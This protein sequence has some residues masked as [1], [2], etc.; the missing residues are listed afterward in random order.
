MPVDP[1]ATW[2]STLAALPKVADTSW[3][4]N[5]AAWVAGRV[6]TITT[7][8][9]N[10]TLSAPLVFVFNQALFASQLISLTPTGDAL[11][12]ITG[13]ADAWKAAIDTTVFPA[14][15]NVAPGAFV[16]PTTPATTFSTVTSVLLDPASVAAAKAKIIELATAAPVADV[17]DSE[18]PVKFREAFL[19]LT[20]TVAGLDS[21]PTPAGPLPL[22]VPN[23]PLI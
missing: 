16:P 6:A 21:T 4:A 14:T 22:T 10:L 9:T 11:S 1:L 23:I 8:P 5:F 2:R 19:L 3:A 18:F 13:F 15:L 20:I 7:N 17:N 12:G